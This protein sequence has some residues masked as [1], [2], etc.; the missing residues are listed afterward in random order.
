MDSEEIIATAKSPSTVD[1]DI[2]IGYN[3][4]LAEL[5]RKIPGI[6]GRFEE[7]LACSSAAGGLKIIASGLVQELTAEAAKR[8]AL[9]A[10]ARILGTPSQKDYIRTIL[11]YFLNISIP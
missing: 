1:T 5:E 2:T 10:G 9:G 6:S 4:A 7:K 11:P 8:G 3:E